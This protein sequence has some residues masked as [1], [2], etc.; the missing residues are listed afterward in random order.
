M[1]C[2]PLKRISPS[3]LGG[4]SFPSGEAIIIS[5]P[6]KGFPTVCHLSGLFFVSTKVALDDSV[7]PK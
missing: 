4:N 1:H 6:G 2:I 7:N 5:T 3:V